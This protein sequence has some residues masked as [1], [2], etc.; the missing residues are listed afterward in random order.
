MRCLTKS[1]KL[2]MKGWT[3]RGGEKE[4][5]GGGIYPSIYPLLKRGLRHPRD[6]GDGSCTCG[7]IKHSFG[8]FRAA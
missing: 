3:V 1:V 7:F 2:V 6:A 8:S 5:E 4:R